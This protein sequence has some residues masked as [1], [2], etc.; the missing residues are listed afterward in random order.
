MVTGVLWRRHRGIVV[1]ILLLMA[2]RGTRAIELWSDEQGRKG[3]LAVTGKTT[4]LASDAPSDPVLFPEDNSET[5]LARLRLGLE[6]THC[7]WMDSELA[8]EQR[9]QWLSGATALGAGSSFLPSQARAAFRLAQLDWEIAADDSF[10]YRHEM[11]RAL[12]ALHPAWG[13]VTVGRQAIGLGRGVMFSAVDVFSPFSPLEVDREWRRGVDA[14][15]AEY[16]LSTTSSAECLA[17]FGESWEQSALLGRLRGY[18]GEIDGALIFG[19]RAEDFMV[20]SALTPVVGEAEVHGELAVFDTHE[21]WP[22]G[23]LWGGR[24]L[25]TKAV[26]GSSYTFDIGKGLTLL[27]EYHYSD[28]GVEDAEDILVRLQDRDFQRRFLRGDTQILGRHGV[29]AQLGYPFS[30]VV[31]GSFLVL[32]NPTDGSG[33]ISPSLKWDLDE[34]VTLLGN[35]F[36]PWGD[37]P[38]AGQFRSE[39]GATSTSLFLQ[40]AIYF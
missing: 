36:V 20:A 1:L 21:A 19:K 14:F 37:E 29:A 30:D 5:T 3:E 12:V 25:A 16:R 11:D 34:N 31:N 40:A 35:I 39:Y 38:S 13:D 17:A 26:V 28:F 8:Y 4:F 6:V 18:L 23:T 15:R 9:A 7:D 27:G 10:T 24:H 22:D 2:P 32:T 33:V